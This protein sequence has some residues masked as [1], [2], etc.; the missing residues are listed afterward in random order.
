MTYKAFYNKII[1]LLPSA[2]LRA[3]VKSGSH[4][5]SEIDL[6]KF[7]EGYAPSFDK[8]VELFDLA[9]EVFTDKE[10]KYHAKKL[11]EHC[12][13]VYD[14]FATPSDAAVYVIEM[15]GS[16]DGGHCVETLVN[17][18]LD[19]AI[20]TLETCARR[21]KRDMSDGEYYKY[22]IKKHSTTCAHKYKD[23][24]N[25]GEI[26]SCKW[27]PK[28]GI[29]DIYAWRAKNEFGVD[30]NTCKRK[31]VC[32]DSH[33]VEYP[34]FLRPFDLVAYKTDNFTP[35]EY[36]EYDTPTKYTDIAYGV[37]LCDMTLDDNNSLSYIIC[38]DSKRIKERRADEKSE[39]GQYYMIYC[40]HEHPS[41][42]ELY[43]PEISELPQGVYDDYL[44]A[45]EE[46]KKIEALVSNVNLSMCDSDDDYPKT[47]YMN[48]ASEPFRLVESGKKTVEVRLYDDKRKKI[49]RHDKIVFMF[50]DYVKNMLTT[51]VTG[52]KR[53]NTFA[54]LM[55][56]D[57]FDK[58]GLQGYTPESAAEAM[59]K[60]YTPEQE[61]KYGVL[62]IE[63]ELIKS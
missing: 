47:H 63:I 36:N 34:P 41:Y 51:R 53:F 5:F 10:T 11:A 58:T 39:D 6:L 33:E 15:R 7:I 46:L 38:L 40:D 4:V 3:A 50:C 48:L 1:A 25:V 54:E 59:Y 18:T 55:Q 49:K 42:A 43:K 16:C 19:D 27:D 12:R 28:L 21:D 62:A 13:K 60:Y 29:I 30:C 56:S 26:C 44:Y 14:Y 9:A 61:K 45:V 37:L 35:I 23:L 8:K 20:A 24:D 57:L 31:H 32:L 2:D 22:E 52:I 17:K